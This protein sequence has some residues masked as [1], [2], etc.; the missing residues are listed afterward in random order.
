[1]NSTSQFPRRY[2]VRP[3]GESDSEGSDDDFLVSGFTSSRPSKFVHTPHAPSGSSN[4][5]TVE[6]NGGSS[7]QV[8]NGNNGDEDWDAEVV[9]SIPGVSSTPVAESWGRTPSE[10]VRLACMRGNLEKLKQLFSNGASPGVNQ[11]FGG[12]E[13]T[14]L[15]TACMSGQPQV[16]EYL[17][18]EKSANPDTRHPGAKITPLM[19]AVTCGEVNNEE[20]L[21]QCVQTLVEAGADLNK[22]NRFGHTALV[23]AIKQ[24]RNLLAN[25]LIEKGADV[26]I[27]DPDGQTALFYAAMEGNG[28]ICRLLLEHE[29]DIQIVDRQGW[30]A[31]ETA[32]DKGFDRLSELLYFARDTK[33]KPG[34]NPELMKQI[35]EEAIRRRKDS[36]VTESLSIREDMSIE[37]ILSAVE[38]SQYLSNFRKHKITYVQFLN[39]DDNQLRE[40]GINEV[41]IREKILDNTK[42]IHNVP[43]QSSSLGTIPMNN[44]KVV[45]A[46]E[47]VCMI[48]NI[49]DHL[50]NISGTLKYISQRIKDKPLALRYDVERNRIADLMKFCKQAEKNCSQVKKDV[51][52]VHAIIGGL[53]KYTELQ[54]AGEIP[55][56]TFQSSVENK[57]SNKFHLK[58]PVGIGASL[59]VLGLLQNRCNIFGILCKTLKK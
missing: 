24:K 8:S 44:N 54:V 25:Y 17:L 43:W 16:V 22:Q 59:L 14:P 13:E 38:A 42:H 20:I 2:N 11:V 30:T 58:L 48:V 23:I 31:P 5:A 19:A 53:Q 57:K 18:K 9:G 45:T 1:M 34:L 32:Q 29:A 15:V 46:A 6:C 41:G 28:R 33:W 3:A 51:V 47:A 10:A 52:E 35:D 49:R 55:E 21:L 40:I 4:A 56:C 37:L 27:T 7:K 12:T 26:N 36:T 50:Q 39:L